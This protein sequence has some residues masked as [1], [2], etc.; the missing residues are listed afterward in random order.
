LSDL[1]SSLWHLTRIALLEITRIRVVDL[2]R[3]PPVLLL[4][5]QDPA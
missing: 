3:R 4:L 1:D 5:L 2:G